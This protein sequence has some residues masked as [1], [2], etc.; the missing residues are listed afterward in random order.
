[1]RLADWYGP[2][3]RFGTIDKTYA[4]DLATRTPETDGPIYMVNFM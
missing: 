3:M 1:M 4:V 2:S